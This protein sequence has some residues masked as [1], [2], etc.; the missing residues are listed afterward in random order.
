MQFQTLT[1]AQQIVG[2]YHHRKATHAFLV[3]PSGTPR[4]EDYAA[5]LAIRF[6]TLPPYNPNIDFNTP[7]GMELGERE[8]T[9]YLLGLG[10]L[11]AEFLAVKPYL[12]SVSPDRAE[13]YKLHVE[14]A[15]ADLMRI[16]MSE[17]AIQVPLVKAAK[18]ELALLIHDLHAAA[19]YF[20]CEAMG[21]VPVSV[22]PTQRLGFEPQRGLV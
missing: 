21:T 16:D 22:L 11:A 1:P 19:A 7:E 4:H 15:V 6:S 13:S 12:A 3:A 10:V 17:D 2:A 5:N 20:Q 14:K 9:A 8:H 18:R